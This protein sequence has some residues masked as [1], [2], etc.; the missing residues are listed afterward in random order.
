MSEK[1]KEEF[2]LEIEEEEQAYLD[3]FEEESKKHSA[4]D[5]GNE[6]GVASEPEDSPEDEDPKTGDDESP[7][8]G[9]TAGTAAP[10]E[11]NDP[12]AWIK[13][14]P[15]EQQEQAK[16][17]QHNAVSNAGRISAMQRRMNEMQARLQAREE[18]YSTGR[19]KP[20]DAP[21]PDE[22][23]EELSKSLKEFTEQYPQL[24]SSVREM[25]SSERRELEAQ[26]QQQIAPLKEE[27][28]AR[29]IAEARNKLEE[30]AAEIFDTAN[31]NI[32]YTDVLNSELYT[33]VFL[34]SQPEDFRRIATTTS[35]PETALWVLR[36]FHEFA[37]KY[38]VENGLTEEVNTSKADKTSERR[39]ARVAKSSTP[40][41]R[42]AVTDP[43]D[44]G[45][46]EAMF[47]R[48]NS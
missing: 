16:A 18:A 28:R 41:S 45:D 21:A 33:D 47:K 6:E 48:M 8:S 11:E 42:S 1:T 34:Q 38:A 14:L 20:S 44:M 46:Y 23:N 22:D 35:D 15:P 25:V 7:K 2:D 10:E 3:A 31:T 17:L 30:G 26:M 19:Q 5:N 36:Q 43:E 4:D 37:E 24:A 39:R 27:T 9:G 12:Y 32:H 40:P 29:Q 13:D